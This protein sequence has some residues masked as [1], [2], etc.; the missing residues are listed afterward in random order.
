[1]AP[2]D[3]M[4]CIG[5][6]QVEVRIETHDLNGHRLPLGGARGERPFQRRSDWPWSER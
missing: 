5:L 1:M 2:A 4:A 3:G 6:G